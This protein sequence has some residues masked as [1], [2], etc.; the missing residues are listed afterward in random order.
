MAY[1]FIFADM[2]AILYRG[3]V[4]GLLLLFIL[5]SCAS[6]YVVQS[7][8]KQKTDNTEIAAR[9]KLYENLIKAPSNPLKAE[10]KAEKI[11]RENVRAREIK[12]RMMNQKAQKILSTAITYLG[13]PYRYGGSTRRGMDCSGLVQKSFAANDIL[14][15][16]NSKEQAKKGKLVTKNQ[17]KRGDLVF[18]ATKGGR[19]VSHVGIILTPN[20]VK[21]SFI[22]ASFSRGVMV[23]KLDNSYWN[24]R[25]VSARRVITYNGKS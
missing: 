23:S 19:R 8:K 3:K 15:P 11:L 24:R 2:I 7:T 9:I 21:S 18:F 10:E 4:S 12:A 16:R 1:F 13:V 22:H 25:Y 14:L 5:G 20:G 17:L 6:N